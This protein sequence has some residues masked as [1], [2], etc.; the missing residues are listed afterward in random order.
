MGEFTAQSGF[1]RDEAK[2]AVQKVD[3]DQI[4][5]LLGPLSAKQ[6]YT[7]TLDDIIYA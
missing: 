2:A 3:F 7:Q 6:N 4:K 5:I 1:N